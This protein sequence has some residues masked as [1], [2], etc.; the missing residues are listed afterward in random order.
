[1]GEPVSELR[2]FAR[3]APRA[4]RRCWALRTLFSAPRCAE[5]GAHDVSAF[6]ML[7]EPCAS[8]VRAVCFWRKRRVGLVVLTQGA[9]SWGAERHEL[10]NVRRLVR[11]APRGREACGRWGRR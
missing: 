9:F 6:A 3:C 1:M 10:R 8:R 4:P 5:L 7:V 11:L 2:P